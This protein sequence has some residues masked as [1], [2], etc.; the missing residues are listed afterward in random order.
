MS[1]VIHRRI[2]DAGPMH[3]R[4]K[5]ADRRQLQST[6]S[7]SPDPVPPWIRHIQEVLGQ[8][9]DMGFEIYP[10]CG[11]LLFARAS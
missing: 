7:L 1:A 8:G 5:N 4:R 9:Q 3:C 6:C 10:I 2:A 11:G